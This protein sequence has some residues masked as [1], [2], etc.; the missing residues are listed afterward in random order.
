MLF[1]KNESKSYHVTTEIIKRGYV[2]NIVL[3]LVG[4]VFCYIKT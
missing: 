1:V 4:Y 3:L 2:F